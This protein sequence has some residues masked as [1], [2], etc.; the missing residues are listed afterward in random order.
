MAFLHVRDR[1]LELRIAYV[2]ARGAGQEENLVMLRETLPAAT[3]TGPGDGLALTL[4]SGPWS[5]FVAPE[6]RAV[7]LLTSGEVERASATDDVDAF[8]LVVDV[9][10]DAALAGA[11]AAGALASLVRDRR[12]AP[13]VIVQAS[14]TS[15]LAEPL[16]AAIEEVRK[17]EGWG[18][19]DA[20]LPLGLGVLETLHAA[21]EAVLT[22]SS[23]PTEHQAP[24]GPPED[25][26]GAA[27]LG[28][29]LLS[30]LATALTEAL[31][32]PLVEALGAVV[33]AR[34]ESSVATVVA[35]L[36]ERFSGSASLLRRERAEDAARRQADAVARAAD[37]KQRDADKQQLETAFRELAA[38]MRAQ[39]S[40][41]QSAQQSALL[42]LH[43]EIAA[44]SARLET[45]DGHLQ[46]LGERFTTLGAGTQKVVLRVAT[47]VDA[48]ARATAE[49][50]TSTATAQREQ[51][52]TLTRLIEEQGETTAS[53]L[54][55]LEEEL[56]R[57][58]K[59]WFG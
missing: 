37:A 5:R 18:R 33:S 45:A 56:G 3:P 13:S 38:E 59:T 47:A 11:D 20:C 58:K 4:A 17:A 9:R 48:A 14:R 16:P 57:K 24:S 31:T 21:V 26:E 22:T 6:T 35:A 36:D 23:E 8:V 41:Q 7:V 55:G 40:V 29:P 34:L 51:M 52:E 44:V 28:H 15:E 46:A 10:G 32:G 27:R 43:A 12:P 1:T 42:P 2:G 19:A 53:R 30:Y 54:T 49:Q 50:A 39:Q 25:R